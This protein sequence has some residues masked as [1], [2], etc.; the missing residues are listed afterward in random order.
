MTL[1]DDVM[2]AKPLFNTAQEALIHYVKEYEVLGRKHGMT[3]NEFWHEAE[4]SSHNTEDYRKIMSLRMRINM[5][6]N[7]IKEG[8]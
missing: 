2:N 5:C 8:L 6:V 1:Y 4:H 7:M 3:G